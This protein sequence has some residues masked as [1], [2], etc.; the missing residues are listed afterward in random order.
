MCLRGATL[1]LCAFGERQRYDDAEKPDGSWPG[2]YKGER[3]VELHLHNLADEQSPGLFAHAIQT[4]CVGYLFSAQC[5]CRDNGVSTL[6]TQWKEMV[7]ILFPVSLLLKAV[8]LEWIILPWHIIINIVPGI[9]V[10][11]GVSA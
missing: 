6:L 9:N 11:C 7:H 8:H 2:V 5:L 4:E 1:K 10:R 3:I